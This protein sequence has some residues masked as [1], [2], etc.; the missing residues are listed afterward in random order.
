MNELIARGI[1]PEIEERKLSGYL[2]SHD[3]EIG[4]S[5]AEFFNLCQVTSSVQLRQVL[6]Q[7]W[8]LGNSTFLEDNVQGSKYAIAADVIFPDGKARRLKTVWIIHFEEPS[9]AKFVTAHPKKLR[10]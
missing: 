5:K 2:L 1:I 9:I 10:Q 6:L 8:M 3:H 7:V 4:R